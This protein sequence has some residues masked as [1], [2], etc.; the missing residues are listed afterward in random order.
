[1]LTPLLLHAAR[2]ACLP[3]VASGPV[4]AVLLPVMICVL[5][6]AIEEHRVD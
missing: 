5:T 2:L 6:K 4:A 1:M 3:V